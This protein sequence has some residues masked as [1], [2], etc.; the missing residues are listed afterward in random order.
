MGLFHD[1]VDDQ[2][3]R[4]IGVE[5]A[6]D[7]LDTDKHAATLTYGQPGVL[8]GSFSKLLQDHDGQVIEPHSIRYVIVILYTKP[9]TLGFPF[10]R[11][12][13]CVSVCVWFMPTTT[14]TSSSLGL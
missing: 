12:C 6:G 2:E 3:I 9:N 7:G 8:H 1:F 5:A 11:K 4:L 13:V 10:F 14:T